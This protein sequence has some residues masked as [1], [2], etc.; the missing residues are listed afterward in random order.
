MNEIIAAIVGAVVAG[1]LA[2]IAYVYQQRKGN[3]VIVNMLSQSP[4]ITFSN[5]VQKKLEIIYNG[6]KVDNLVLTQFVI[7]NQGDKIIKPLILDVSVKPKSGNFTFAELN[8]SDP[9]EI[10]KSI[11]DRETGAVAIERP[12]LNPKNKYQEE[13]IKVSVFSDVEL[14]FSV[15]GGGEDWAT[16]LVGQD[17]LDPKRGYYFSIFLSIAIIGI[18]ILVVLNV[19]TN[20][21]DLVT[22]SVGLVICFLFYIDRFHIFPKETKK[23][24]SHRS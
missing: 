11:M 20:F 4:Q 10:T 14:D 6:K 7:F 21:S 17:E 2:L 12:Y 1:I 23:I 19:I 18:M 22:I 3:R 16:K 24:L 8:I 5:S 13:E 15:S 9:Q